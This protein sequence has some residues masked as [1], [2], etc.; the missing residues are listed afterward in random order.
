MKSIEYAGDMGN[1]VA[2][3]FLILNYYNFD[4]SVKELKH[5]SKVAFKYEKYK[6]ASIIYYI[7]RLQGKIEKGFEFIKVAADN[8]DSQSMFI[9]GKS[10]IF[11]E[12]CLKN[13]KKGIEYLKSSV[14]KA[15]PLAQCL[16]ADM[17]YQGT[18][19]PKNY[20]Q[21]YYYNSLAIQQGIV[22]G[23]NLQGILYYFGQ[24][25]KQIM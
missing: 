1:M 7:Y 14:N 20:H 3:D 11:A 23:Y 12:F 6:Y 16:L 10:L 13:E 24:G 17:N 21:A 9:L 5:Y 15:N 4:I 22:E 8:W 18:I 25:L 19:I 2:L